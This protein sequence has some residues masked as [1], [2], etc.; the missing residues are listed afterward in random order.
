M[1]RKLDGILL[2]LAAMLS[3]FMIVTAGGVTY[4]L[5]EPFKP[6]SQVSVS[7]PTDET[8]TR[9][10]EFKVGDK[11]YYYREGEIL[12]TSPRIVYQ[13][14]V[15]SPEGVIY[16][17]FPPTAPIVTKLGAFKQHYFAVVLPDFLPCGDYE[18]KTTQIYQINPL[19]N[20]VEQ[21]LPSIYFKVV[22]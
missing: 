12:R 6:Y 21:R 22:K 2:S 8:G 10:N 20:D 13:M 5:L 15:S 1:M 4:W 9:K 16:I 14:V 19:Q 7:Y 11:L 17:R 3:V 18:L